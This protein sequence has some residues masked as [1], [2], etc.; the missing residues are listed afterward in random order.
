MNRLWGN[1][2]YLA[3]VIDRVSTEDASTWRNEITPF[4]NSLGVIVFDPC[5]KKLHKMH[6][7]P[8]E[9]IVF[10]KL[11]QEK[12]YQEFKDFG[13]PIRL[14]DLR[15]VDKSDFIIA[16]IDMNVFNCGTIEEIV[17]ANRQKKPVLLWCPQGLQELA[18][19]FKLMLPLSLIFERLDD[20]KTYLNNINSA[21][22]IDD[23]NRWRFFD[24][25]ELYNQIMPVKHALTKELMWYAKPITDTIS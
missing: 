17:L 6:D 19:W 23:L 3:G 14:I 24:Y 22:K 20:L 4:L 15:M 16:K 1:M 9:Q 25:P 7:I 21:E 5:N 13:E 11:K 2:C 12:K 10:K 8:N 18:G